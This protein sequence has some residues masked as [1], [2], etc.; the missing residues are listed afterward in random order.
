MDLHEPTYQLFKTIGCKRYIGF[1][2]N[3][4]LSVTIA[5]VPKGT[6]EKIVGINPDKN[7]KYYTNSQKALEVMELLKDGQSFSN[8][9]T[10]ATYNDNE[11]SDIIN[12]KLMVSKSSVAINN[13]DFTIKVS[14]EYNDYIKQVIDMYERDI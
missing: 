6:L 4:K 8:C 12:G 1:D 10:E 14:K 13:I 11:H 5:G 7:K 2:E 3:N 9:K